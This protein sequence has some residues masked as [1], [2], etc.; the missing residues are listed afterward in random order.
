MGTQLS[1]YLQDMQSY[2][3]AVIS[4]GGNSRQDL[5]KKF[6]QCT[7]MLKFNFMDID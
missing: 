7:R 2:R 4:L 1:E 3:Y 6:N 5:D